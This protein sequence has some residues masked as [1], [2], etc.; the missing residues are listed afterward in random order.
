ME[1]QKEEKQYYDISNNDATNLMLKIEGITLSD[2][3]KEPNIKIKNLDIYDRS[4]YIQ[5]VDS[6][7]H[8][9]N[10]I[11]KKG[12]IVYYNNIFVDGKIEILVDKNIRST[13]Q[14]EKTMKIFNIPCLYF[15]DKYGEKKKF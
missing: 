11:F 5:I 7:K 14:I 4:N 1:M 8:N 2:I 10:L 13:L 12:I 9:Y 15:Y 3:I 6:S